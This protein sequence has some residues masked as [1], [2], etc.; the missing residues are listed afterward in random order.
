MQDAD[1]RTL[2]RAASDGLARQGPVAVAGRVRASV[3][4]DAGEVDCGVAREGE[5]A[6]VS[7]HLRGVLGPDRRLR[8]HRGP[9]GLVEL[10]ASGPRVV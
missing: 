1:A 2:D 7:D 9:H 10:V 8:R 5:V 4:V 6:G 3:E